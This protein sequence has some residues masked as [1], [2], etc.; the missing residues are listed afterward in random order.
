[1]PALAPSLPL[2]CFSLFHTRDVDQARERVARID[3]RRCPVVMLTGEYDFSCTPEMSRQTAAKIPG[4]QFR[5]MQGLGHF[6]MTENPE[7]FLGYLRPALA[8]L[9]K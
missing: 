8:G 4:A 1:M 5:M 6:P 2:S 9:G 3:T 7:A